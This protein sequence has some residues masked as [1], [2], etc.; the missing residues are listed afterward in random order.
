MIEITMPH[1]G[2][3]RIDDMLRWCRGQFG[4]SAGDR[5]DERYRWVIRITGPTLHAC[6]SRETDATL[7]KMRWL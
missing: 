4:S 5:P 1:P 6:F 2:V 7:F 3:I